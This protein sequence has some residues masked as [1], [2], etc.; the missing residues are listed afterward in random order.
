[1]EPATEN[2]PSAARVAVGPGALLRQAREAAGMPPEALAQRLR[3]EPKVIEALESEAYERLPGPAFTKGYLRSIAKELGIDPVPL[4]AQYTALS[5]EAEPALADF[6]SRAPAQITTANARIK[7]VSYTLGAVVL[8][9]IAIWWQR[10]YAS[11]TAAPAADGAAL[12]TEPMAPPEPSIPLPYTYTIVEHAG[13]PLAQPET[14]RRRTDGSIPPLDEEVLPA[15]AAQAVTGQQAE[16][17]PTTTPDAAA[18]DTAQSP[19]PTAVKGELILAAERDSW[20]EITD[21]NR[22]RLYFGLIKGGERIG[23][24]GKPP[25]DLVIGNAPAVTATFRGAA[26]DVRRHAINGVARMAVGDVQ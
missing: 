11:E 17:A 24:S 5:N 2:Q 9:L 18:T 22:S 12:A 8:I 15:L 13:A 14:W 6:E 4:L 23:V 3:L 19:S 25:Y 26:V 16:A 20:I 21:L 1:V 10:H 7:L